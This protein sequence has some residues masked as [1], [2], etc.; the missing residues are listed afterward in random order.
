VFGRKELLDFFENGKPSDAGVEH[1][2]REF[3]HGKR[4]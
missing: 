3:L 4:L 2:D 1:A